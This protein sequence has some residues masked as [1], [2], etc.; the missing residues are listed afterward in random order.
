MSGSEL[1]VQLGDELSRELSVGVPDHAAPGSYRLELWTQPL[2]AVRE[3]EGA[4]RC[5]AF[6]E[7]RLAV[8]VEIVSD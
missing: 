1:Y 5:L 8:D 2:I 7:D 6:C 4:N 3:C